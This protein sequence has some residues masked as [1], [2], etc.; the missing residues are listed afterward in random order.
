MIVKPSGF[1]NLE[2]TLARTFV[3]LKPTLT[4]IPSD[5]WISLL[6]SRAI[7]SYGQWNERLRPVMSAKASSI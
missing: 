7:L 4:V 2:A 1:S 6:I 5:F 3:M